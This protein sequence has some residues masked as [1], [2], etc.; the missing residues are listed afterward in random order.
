MH[1]NKVKKGEK[2]FL[3]IVGHRG[4]LYPSEK[5]VHV[6][7]DSQCNKLAWVGGS[8]SRIPVTLPMSA[9]FVSGSPNTNIA[10]W[11]SYEK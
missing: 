11:L 3:S 10:V 4:F 6:L 2:V 8:Q 7:H 5:Q 1:L 9:V